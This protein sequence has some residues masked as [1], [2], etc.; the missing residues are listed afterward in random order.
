MP[1]VLCHTREIPEGKSKGFTITI[2][3]RALELFVVHFRGEF[4]AYQNH[5][6]HTGINLN[7]QAD[8]FLDITEQRIQCSTHGALFRI[9]D[10][11]CEWGPCIGKH[12]RPL[13]IH[14]IDDQLF[15]LNEEER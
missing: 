9:T 1:D 3:D 7:W 2:N 15:L 10:G 4:Y 12:L 13:T 5:C 14:E 6:P 11:H 8:Q